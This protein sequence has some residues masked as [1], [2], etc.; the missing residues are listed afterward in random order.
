MQHLDDILKSSSTQA[1]GSSDKA[2]DAVW[3]SAPQP[4]IRL[5]E[6]RKK[7]KRRPEGSETTSFP[8]VEK[9]IIAEEVTPPKPIKQQ[10]YNIINGMFNSSPDAVNKLVDWDAFVTAMADAG[11]AA[12][13]SSGSAVIFEPEDVKRGWFAK[14]V[15]HRPH[16]VAKIDSI[17]LRSMGKRM[18]K[19]FGWSAETFVVQ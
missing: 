2:A 10:S 13:Q 5:A 7:V 12:R 19:W 6:E 14:I 3:Q 9:L 17:M 4:S 8:Q 15:F 16:P 1:L 11:F 18:E